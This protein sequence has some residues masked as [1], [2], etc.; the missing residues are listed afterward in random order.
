ML[1][2]N[3]VSEHFG[4][5]LTPYVVWCIYQTKYKP[6]PRQYVVVRPQCERVMNSNVQNIDL[7]VPPRTARVPTCLIQQTTKP[8]STSSCKLFL[9]LHSAH[10]SKALTRPRSFLLFL[11][12]MST[13]ELFFTDPVSTDRGPVLNSS[14][15]RAANSSAVISPVGFWGALKID[16][17]KTDQQTL[18]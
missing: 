4:T 10:L 2:V 7:L 16:R 17:T 3:L 5:R 12:L 6:T 11:Q 1:R 13:C 8:T 9:T 14:C 18:F 15:S